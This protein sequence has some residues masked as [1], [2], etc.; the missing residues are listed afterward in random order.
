MTV[1]DQASDPTVYCIVSSG[2]EGVA[3]Q[4]ASL[5]ANAIAYLEDRLGPVGREAYV[6]L[7]GA[8]P[9]GGAQ[10]SGRGGVGMAV[11]S[12]NAWEDSPDPIQNL[13][14]DTLVVHELVHHWWGRT[15]R[16]TSGGEGDL[17]LVESMAEY[18]ALRTMRETVSGGGM[19]TLTARRRERLANDLSTQGDP[20]PLIE[21]D[22]NRSDLHHLVYDKGSAALQ[23]LQLYAGQE[24]FDLA[25]RRFL[26]DPEAHGGGFARWVD[27]LSEACERDLAM[28]VEYWFGRTGLPRL[29][30]IAAELGATPGGKTLVQVTVRQ[31]SPAF[32]FAFRGVIACEGGE[33]IPVTLEVAAEDVSTWTIELPPQTGAPLWLR[34]DPEGLCAFANRGNELSGLLNVRLEGP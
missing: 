26:D 13:G 23:M 1:P 11:L 25:C 5:A 28:F 34:L 29:A 6:L 14:R 27:M 15:F 2:H 4:L 30:G 22:K 21:I 18:W 19:L 31:E 3:V 24:A 32:P 10:M 16:P 33:Q 8:P 12:Q 20:V 7:Q 9:D 17:I